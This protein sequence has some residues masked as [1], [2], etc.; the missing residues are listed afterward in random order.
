MRSNDDC[1]ESYKDGTPI[2]PVDVQPSNTLKRGNGQDPPNDQLANTEPSNNVHFSFF[3]IH[4]WLCQ[5]IS[6]LEG[7]LDFRYDA[8]T[9]WLEEKIADLKGY[10]SDLQDSFG[11]VYT[12]RNDII[13]ADAYNVV[14][15]DLSNIVEYVEGLIVNERV[16]HDDIRETLGMLKKCVAN[17]SPLLKT[18]SPNTIYVLPRIP[19]LTTTLREIIVERFDLE[20]FKTLCVDLNVHYDNLRG[21]GLEAK[22]RELIAYLNRLGALQLLIDAIR[23]ARGLII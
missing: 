5:L 3:T 12:A 8:T 4:E 16:Q 23:H 7:V 15:T 17:L 1:Q 20:E 2:A 21:E 6:D 14:V 13:L 11:D 9:E 10:Q 18:S 19:P 22:A